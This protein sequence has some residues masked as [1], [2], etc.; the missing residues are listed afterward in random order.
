MRTHAKQREEIQQLLDSSGTALALISCILQGGEAYSALEFFRGMP[1][2]Q[3][4]PS[5]KQLGYI[6]N[7]LKARVQ[8]SLPES[9]RRAEYVN[10]AVDG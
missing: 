5:Q 1:A 4:L 2:G 9:C 7:I 6:A 8:E 3:W 10:L